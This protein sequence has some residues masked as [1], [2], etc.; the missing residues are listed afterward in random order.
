MDAP[1]ILEAADGV[2][3]L[4]LNRPAARNALSL[5]LVRSLKSALDAYVA[6]DALRCAV[7]T[8]AD[9]AFCA[10][11]DLKDFSA[12]DAP[13][14]E[15][16]DL[17]RALPNLGKPLIAA[18][19]GA[20]MTGGLELALGCDFILASDRAR[21]GDTHNRIGALSGSG[22]GS[23]LPHAVGTRFAKQM[24]LSCEPIDAA[25]ALRVGLVNEI[26]AHE[27]LLERARAVAVMISAHDPELVRLSKK[28]LDAGAE[29][30]LGEA[31][32]IERDV[33]AERKA[34]GAMTWTSKRD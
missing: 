23:R 34:R 13:R 14:G 6:D 22:M 8:G 26:V 21:F 9:P 27:A 4:T 29:T 11:L 16:G 5:A 24:V 30:T 2:L 32:M 19:N 28:V 18:V 15:V 20:A 3:V 33:L 12:P 1:L 7:I 31:L 10:G 25:T 17:I